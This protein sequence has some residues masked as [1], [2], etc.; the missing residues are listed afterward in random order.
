MKNFKYKINKSY[1]HSLFIL[2][3]S[4]LLM[5]CQ[6]EKVIE[7]NL[8]AEDNRKFEIAKQYFLDAED[9]KAEALL[10]EIKGKDRRAL[11][12][13]GILYEDTSVVR[14]NE[15]QTFNYLKQAADQHEINAMQLLTLN[16]QEDIPYKIDKKTF[17][18]YYDHLDNVLVGNQKYSYQFAMCV[19]A[20]NHSLDFIKN[21]SKEDVASYMQY[22]DAQE[23]EVYSLHVQILGNIMIYKDKEKI[24]RQIKSPVMKLA[25]EGNPIAHRILGQILIEEDKND[26]GIFWLYLASK[27]IEDYSDLIKSISP[28]EKN[29]LEKEVS[30]WL[31]S[32]VKKNN[33]LNRTSKHCD[34]EEFSFIDE[35]SCILNSFSID[36]ECV[37]FSLGIQNNK[38][39]YAFNIENYRFSK[40]FLRCAKS[41]LEGSK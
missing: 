20:Y 32:M 27:Q 14:S 31:H 16:F 3:I 24:L 41:Y 11:T 37:Y 18:K 10:H 12:L 29:N 13:L 28:S 35:T 38:E 19:T 39:I 6:Q 5:S 8:S 17:N 30:H 23:E 40:R 22:F 25:N 9:D 2:V 21:C 7:P 1:L 33:H 36:L 15:K 4:I 34:T 26:E